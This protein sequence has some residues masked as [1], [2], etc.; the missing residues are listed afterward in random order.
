MANIPSTHKATC[1]ATGEVIDVIV[2]DGI[3]YYYRGQFEGYVVLSPND[4]IVKPNYS[5]YKLL[6]IVA[7]IFLIVMIILPK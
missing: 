3:I 4:Y 2:V 7:F 5:C 6:S 1:K